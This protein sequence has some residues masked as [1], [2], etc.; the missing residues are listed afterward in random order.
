Q[1]HG[2]RVS[3]GRSAAGASPVRGAAHGPNG[4]ARHSHLSVG[5]SDLRNDLRAVVPQ[6]QGCSQR[7]GGGLVPIV[8]TLGVLAVLVA[9][10]PVITATLGRHAGWVLAGGYVLAAAAFLPATTAAIGGQPLTW[11]RPWIPGLDVELAF[12]A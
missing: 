7:T 2:A 8:W 5:W 6:P 1:S 9:F 4:F 10:T 11:S 3:V 12:R